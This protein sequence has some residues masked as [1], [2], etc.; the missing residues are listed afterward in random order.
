M[1][2]NYQITVDGLARDVFYRDPQTNPK[3]AVVW[4]HARG[5]TGMGFVSIKCPS[6]NDHIDLGPNGLE[7]D[8]GQEWVFPGMETRPGY[9]YNAPSPMTDIHFLDQLMLDTALRFPSIQRIW[10]AGH[11][12]GGLLV[13][14]LYAWNTEFAQNAS[15]YMASGAPEPNVNLF[16]WLARPKNPR[17]FCLWNGSND[18]VLISQLGC[19]SWDASV[20]DLKA[21]NGCSGTIPLV[22]IG[23]C[24]GKDLRRGSPS[25]GCGAGTPFQRLVRTMGG[26]VWVN[27]GGCSTGQHAIEFFKTTGFG[28]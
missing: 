16:D 2:G 20:A 22:S 13:W 15:G 21:T 10:V 7:G 1:T 26:H 8:F 6:G 23:S 3:D 5:G 27:S 19:K 9:P 11:S 18:G 17:P 24:D 28:T 12:S 4:L 14:A 25:G